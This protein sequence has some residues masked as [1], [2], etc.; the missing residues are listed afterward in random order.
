MPENCLVETD[1]LFA[2]N[3]EDKYHQFAINL[4][5]DSSKGRIR[6]FLS[7]ISPLE[8]TLVM[9]SYE[10]SEHDIAMALKAFDAA[11]RRYVSTH[12]PEITLSIFITAAEL[13]NRHNELSFFDSFHAAV[14]LSNNFI[15]IGTD[16]K[17]IDVVLKEGGLARSFK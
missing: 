4:L 14:A 13:R 1:F 10:L 9:R 8:A 7:P 6:L 2:L 15:Y 3:P 16:K 11:L 5:E 17:I 12:F